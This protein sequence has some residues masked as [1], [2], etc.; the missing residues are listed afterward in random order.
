MENYGNKHCKAHTLK[1]N[2]IIFKYAN[3]Y[4][5]SRIEG[6][7]PSKRR[8]DDDAGNHSETKFASNRLVP[9][10]FFRKILSGVHSSVSSI[11][12]FQFCSEPFA[13]SIKIGREM[14]D[15]HLISEWTFTTWTLQPPHSSP[16]LLRQGWPQRSRVRWQG[17][18]Q[19]L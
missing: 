1:S 13:G 14:S 17:A 7:F 15:I 11:Q 6:I 10:T 9:L 18:E 4:G 2:E 19:R 5:T 3:V 8:W 12:S 16:H